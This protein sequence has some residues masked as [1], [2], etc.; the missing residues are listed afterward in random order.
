MLANVLLEERHF[1][2]PNYGLFNLMASTKDR[3][4]IPRIELS[5]IDTSH[6]LNCIFYHFLIIFNCKFLT[7]EFIV[8]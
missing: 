2:V 4:G 1:G 6:P 3:N 8:L 7:K 5:I